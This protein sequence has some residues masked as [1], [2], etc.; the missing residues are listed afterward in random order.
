MRLAPYPD[1]RIVTREES[2]EQRLPETDHATYCVGLLFDDAEFIHLPTDFRHVGLHRTAGY[3]LGVDP[4]EVAPR[5]ALAD[6]SRPIA[7]PYVCIATQGSTKIAH[8]QPLP[9]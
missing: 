5:I 1:T 3:I 2:V 7:E 6:D 9:E 8:L 4:T